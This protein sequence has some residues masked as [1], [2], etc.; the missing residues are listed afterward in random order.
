MKVVLI[1]CLLTSA[2]LASAEP[3]AVH[4]LYLSATAPTVTVAPR[5][6]GRNS[7]RMPELEYAFELEPRCAGPFTPRSLSLMIA[8]SR[9]ALTEGELADPET[10]GDVRL[11]VPAGQ[12]APIPLQGFC[13]S[14]PEL[15]G[16]DDGTES[17][18]VLPATFSVQASLL[19]ASDG[20]QAIT[21]TSAVLDVTLVCAPDDPAGAVTGDND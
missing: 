2:G 20:E 19:C 5:P 6:E 12:I 14:G 16:T 13:V 1:P 4:S 9:R 21:Y 17:R 11:T 3:D 18:L 7:L 15:A 10:L 8:D